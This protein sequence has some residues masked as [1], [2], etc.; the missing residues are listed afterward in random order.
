VWFEPGL[1]WW[2]SCDK[3]GIHL[4]WGAPDWTH[5]QYPFAQSQ[6]LWHVDVFENF[7]TFLS[8]FG[9]ELGLKALKTQFLENFVLVIES[10]RRSKMSQKEEIFRMDTYFWRICEESHPNGYS[11][12]RPKWVSICYGVCQNGRT[13][14]IHCP[15]PETV[16]RRCLKT[17]FNFFVTVW[18]WIRS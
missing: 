4:L 10:R 12:T 17:F 13:N 18:N 6:K 5:F 15:Q 8:L 3:M 9:I 16:T 2:L 1:S 7:L 11:P 14:S